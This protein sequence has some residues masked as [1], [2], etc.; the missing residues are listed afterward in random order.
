MVRY[1]IKYNIIESA[2]EVKRKTTVDISN[3][4]TIEP[5]KNPI[6]LEICNKNM[7]QYLQYIEFIEKTL[8]ARL[9]TKIVYNEV[10]KIKDKYYNTST[11]A[12]NIDISQYNLEVHHEFLLNVIDILFLSILHQ[13]LLI[14]F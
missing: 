11:A 5:T 13:N 7:N 6:V 8:S 2:Q 9:D 3:G 12:N 14:I 1:K 4:V 10:Q